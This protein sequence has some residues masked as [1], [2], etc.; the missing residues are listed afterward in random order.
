MANLHTPSLHFYEKSHRDY[1]QHFRTI[2]DWR[3]LL[4][5][6]PALSLL[7]RTD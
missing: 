7:G 3:T 2:R 6:G 1:F 4:E 5:S